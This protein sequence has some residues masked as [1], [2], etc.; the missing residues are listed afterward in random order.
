MARIAHLILSHQNPAAVARLA[1]RLSYPGDAV[2]VH[3]DKKTP[4]KPFAERLAKHQDTWLVKERTSIRWG[5]YSMVAATLRAMAEIL[6]HGHYDFINL[7]S[8]SDYPLRTPAAFHQFLDG[9]T[10]KSFMEMHFEGSPWWEEAQQKTGKYHLVDYGFPGKYAV[11]RVLNAIL[12]TRRFPA[13]LVFTG[14]SQWMTLSAQHVRYVLDFSRTHPDVVRFFRHTW[15]PDEY[16][17]QTILYSGPHR[18]ELVA[19]GLRYVDWSEGKPSPKTLDT[20]DLDALL[21]SEKFFARKFNPSV[22]AQV[23]DR[24]DDALR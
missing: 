14:R 16:F 1:S 24:L 23:L 21:Q 4:I 3:V 7:L 6:A 18:N 20:N 9:Q 2:Y 12:P 15:G 5:A 13:G 11:Q 10:D 17:F 8:E 22:D 19:D